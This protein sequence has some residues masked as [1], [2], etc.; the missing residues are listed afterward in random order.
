[1]TFTHPSRLVF[2]T[3]SP[4]THTILFLVY[5]RHLILLTSELCSL[6]PVW[7]THTRAHMY[8]V[9][10]K[11]N[12]VQAIISQWA[13]GKW[14]LTCTLWGPEKEA[15]GPLKA[16]QPDSTNAKTILVPV[17]PLRAEGLA[18][19]WPMCSPHWRRQA[20]GKRPVTPWSPPPNSAAA[21]SPNSHHRLH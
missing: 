9:L 8:T 3:H 21:L 17:R 2:P 15:G 12:Y 16:R 20:W 1:M 13:T 5:T 19:P 7:N 10:A 11:Q 14:A 4:I 6:I 18:S